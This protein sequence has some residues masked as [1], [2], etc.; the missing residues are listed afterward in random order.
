LGEN[1]QGTSFNSLSSKTET[2][3]PL[4][5]GMIPETTKPVAKGTQRPLLPNP[6]GAPET[7]KEPK[8][9]VDT[10][11]GTPIWGNRFKFL[12]NV[13]DSREGAQA[14]ESTSVSLNLNEPILVGVNE[15]DFEK[16]QR[17]RMLPVG[18]RGQP[19]Q[20]PSKRVTQSTRTDKSKQ[21]VLT[22]VRGRY[23]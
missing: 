22:G 11:R 23:V 20:Q 10:P 18:T 21:S 3:N 1:K 15:N 8:V 2:D 12:G 4:V 17:G 16:T 13:E 14:R 6:M 19:T 9:R 7:D 5:K